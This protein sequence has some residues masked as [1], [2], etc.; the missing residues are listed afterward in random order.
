MATLSGGDELQKRL[1]EIAANLGEGKTLRVGFLENATYPDGTKVAL[2]AA[3]GEWGNPANG[4]KPRPYFRN[5]IASKS[6][7][8]GDDLAKIAIAA[9]FDAN[10]SFSLM[11]EHIK[12]QL[13]ESIRELTEPALSPVTILL[14]ERFGNN[15]QDIKFSDV[16][17]ARRDVAKGVRGSASDKPLIWSGHMLNSVDYDIKD[18]V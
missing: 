6:T 4:Q 3:T 7:K 14:R 13:Q 10:K 9:D 16:Q 11:G 2:A 8:W 5:M 12:S 18:G 1:A 17:A 15:H